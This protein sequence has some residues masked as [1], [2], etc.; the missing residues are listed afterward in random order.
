MLIKYVYQK[1][2]NDELKKPSDIQLRAVPLNKKDA[3]SASLYDTKI[4]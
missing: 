2:P 4:K 3:I 1:W